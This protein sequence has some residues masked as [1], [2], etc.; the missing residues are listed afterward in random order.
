MLFI[1]KTI[2]L[3]KNYVLPARRGTKTALESLN[4]DVA[5]KEIYG[6]LGPNGAGKTTTIKIL[7]GFARPSSGSAFLFDIPVD[8]PEAR[9][10]VGY[11]PEQAYFH[12][13]MTPVEILRTHAALA[14]V[15]RKMR[16]SAIADA[17]TMVGMDEYAKMPISKLSKGLTQRVAIAQALVHQPK[18]LI[19][20]E[21]TSGLDPIGRRYIRDLLAQLRKSGTTIFLSSHLLS[22]IEYLCDRVGILSRGK[23]VAE[24]TPADIKAWQPSTNIRTSHLPATAAQTLEEMGA[25][26]EAR[27]GET[28]VIVQSDQVFKAVRV[29]EEHGL[30]LFSAFAERETLEDAFMRLAA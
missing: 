26:F 22:E 9:K 17:L 5:P 27:E 11:L 1:V 3:S 30:P 19:L 23:L 10:A 20:D 24:G 2:D 4:I 14:A 13:F 18:L 8:H 16:R 21:P 29:L 25:K 28:C 7:L 12:K 6:F 15:P